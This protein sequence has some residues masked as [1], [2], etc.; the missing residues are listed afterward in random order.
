MIQVTMEAEWMAK[1]ENDI[2]FSHEVLRRMRAAGVPVLGAVAVKG[3]ESGRVIQE[4]DMFG[5][6]TFTWEP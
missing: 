4:R 5:N 6:I 2:S 3:T 1:Y